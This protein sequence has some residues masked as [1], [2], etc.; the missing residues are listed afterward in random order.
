MRAWRTG[1]GKTWQSSGSKP[2]AR[3]DSRRLARQ[4]ALA[5]GVG[6]ALVGTVVG[7]AGGG[8]RPQAKPTSNRSQSLDR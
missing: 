8:V 6:A 5:V 4:L 3:R 7:I 1:P 2:D